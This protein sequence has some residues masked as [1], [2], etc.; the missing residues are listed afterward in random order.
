MQFQCSIRLLWPS[1]VKKR[2]LLSRKFTDSAVDKIPKLLLQDFSGRINDAFESNLQVQFSFYLALLRFCKFE[3]TC[4]EQCSHVQLFILCKLVA[5]CQMV[6]L[7][8]ISTT[9]QVI[10]QCA[11]H[12]GLCPAS[13]VIQLALHNYQPRKVKRVKSSV[14][15]IFMAFYLAHQLIH[16]HKT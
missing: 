6:P 3:L 1:K 4:I 11:G 5:N 7:D 16:D 14:C 13:L 10:L 2:L 8:V 9:Q 12:I 15:L